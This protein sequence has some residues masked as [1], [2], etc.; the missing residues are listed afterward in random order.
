MSIPFTQFMRPD[1]RRKDETIDRPEH[2][3]KVALSL[4]ERGVRFEAEVLMDGSVS[5]EAVGPED[6]D[7]DP[8]S[9]AI[10]VVPN[11]PGV[12]EAVDRLVL[13]ASERIERVSQ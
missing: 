4:F 2:V 8:T 5:L 13:K 1:G 6:E 11:G 10:E 3:E 7:G 9:L 12:A